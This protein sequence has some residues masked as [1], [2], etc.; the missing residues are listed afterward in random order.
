MPSETSPTAISEVVRALDELLDPG[1]FDDMGP[2]GLQVPGGETVTRVVTGVSA[3]REL[4]ERAVALRA[5]LVL[6]HHGLFWDFLGA[7]LTPT[8]AERLRPLFVHTIGLAA[9]HL[10]LDAHPEVGNNALLAGLLG[11]ERH[12]AFAGIGRLGEFAGEGIAAADLFARVSEVT[13]REPLVFDAGPE[14]VRRIGLISGSAAKYLPQAVALGLDA[15]LTG[16]PA[17]HV[18]ADA[19]EAGIHFIAAGHYATETFGVR[20]LGDLLAERFGIEHVW[21]DIP[22]P[23]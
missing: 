7:G 19:R 21:V 8:V 23:V 13:R 5:E 12:E 16:E 2:N 17:E 11:C 3:Q 1:A 14:R 6:V 20:R 22:N 15:F 9:Y 10:P 4:I 18:M